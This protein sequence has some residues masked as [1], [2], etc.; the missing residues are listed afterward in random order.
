MDPREIALLTSLFHLPAAIAV[1]SVHPSA[2]ELVIG[3]VCQATSM[4]CPE[5]H[6]LSARIHGHYQRTVADLPCAGRNVILAL[7]VRKFVCPTPSCP[8]RIFT[9]RLPGLV[10]SYALM[11]GRLIALVQVLGLAAGG[12]MGTVLADRSALAT[13]PTTLLR[14]LMQLPTPV[15]RAVRVLG[16]DDFAWKKRFRY[17]TLLVDLERRKIIEVLP[18]RES[19]TVEKWLKEHPDVK[20]VS[21]DR[22]KDFRKAATLAA[23]QAQQ[24][25]D[26]FHLVRNLA[27]TLQVIL[28]HCRAEIRQE[29]SPLPLPE[30]IVRP[31]PTPVTWQQRTPPQIEEERARSPTDSQGTIQVPVLY[32][33]AANY[34]REGRKNRP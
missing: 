3:V 17:G 26:R 7:T 12:Q 10:Q 15:A 20:L 6:Q 27:E 32:E 28:G 8:R 24:V 21:R 33:I 23:P 11:T 31:L 22:G 18:D 14:H 19:A 13:T 5:C 34:A 2:S 30:K 4:P 25:V 9:E 16:I 29:E 1:T